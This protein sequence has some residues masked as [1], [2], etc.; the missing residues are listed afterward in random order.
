MSKTKAFVR[1]KKQDRREERKYN[2]CGKEGNNLKEHKSHDRFSL[3]FCFA[4]FFTIP[5]HS[6]YPEPRHLCEALQHFI[7]PLLEATV[8]TEG[9]GL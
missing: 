2:G 5:F 3:S 4:L 1:N 7:E 8:S 9:C 6:F